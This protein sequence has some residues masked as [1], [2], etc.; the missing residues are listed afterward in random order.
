[1]LD[2]YSEQLESV[3]I[4]EQ[5]DSSSL[6]IAPEK[7]RVKTDKRD[8]PVETLQGWANRGKLNLQ[9]EFQRNFVWSA[10]KASR[11]IES[12]LL[13]IPI[14]VIY[15]AEEHDNTFSVVDGQQRLTAIC[16][17]INGKFPDGQ[18][19]RLSS[20][21]VLTELNRKSFKDINSEL[22]EAILNSI[23]RLIVIEKDSD[24]DVKFEIFE[25]LNLGAEKL[26]DQEL[27][28]CI[29]RGR[30]NDLLR[31]LSENSYMLKV[32]GSSRPHNRMA[33]RQLI[34]RFFAMWRNTH[35]KYKTP[36]KQFLNREMEA[37]RDATE[38]TISE[39]QSVF[40]KS[41]EMSYIVFGQHA[42]RR[43]NPGTEA[44]P[45]GAWEAKKLNVALWDTLLY[46]FSFFEKPQIISISDRIREEFLDL[47]TH[48]SRFVECITS[49]TDQSE[50]VQYRA[51]V[52]LQRLRSLITVNA[53]EPRTFS[54]RLKRELFE[55]D[56]TCQICLQHIHDI[57]DA[58]VDHIEHYWR[59]G[60]TIPENARL[61]HRYCNRSRGGRS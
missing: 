50:K 34:L 33:D 49:T 28:N 21:Q 30:Y 39:M 15:V 47:M 54:L 48:D 13:N 59:G 2:S 19:F 5:E 1:M 23:L 27:R 57:D 3:I 14:P 25:R 44:N 45:N 52:W 42:F 20:L 60:R 4:E 46:A 36:V 18:D 22:Q 37:H 7:R 58:E 17:F 31:H 61:T 43:F 55:L 9:P 12:L 16:S 26:N 40:E 35:L 51:E 8:L 10:S 24:P 29:Y 38:R 41:I 6:D 32:M 11:L 53:N 56:P